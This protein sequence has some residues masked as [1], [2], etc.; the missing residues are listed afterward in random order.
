MADPKDCPLQFSEFKEVDHRKTCPR[1]SSVLER[2]EDEGIVPEEIDT[3]QLELE[4]LLAA[5]S[6]RMQQLHTESQVL[7]DWQDKKDGKKNPKPKE[8]ASPSGKRGRVDER[9]EK[10]SKKAKESGKPGATAPSGPGRPKAKNMQQKLQEYEFIDDA[11]EIP[12]IPRNDVPDRFWAS[13]E[14]YCGD[15]TSENMK[16]LDELIQAHENDAEYFKVPPLGR[17]YSTRW[18]QEDLLEEQKE[19][20]RIGEKK[21]GLSGNSAASQGK[22]VKSMLKRA[23]ALRE[24]ESEVCPFGPLTQRLISALVDENIMMPIEDIIMESNKVETPVE[25]KESPKINSRPFSVPHTRALEARIREE[26]F[27]QGLL[28]FDEKASD[29]EEDEVLA[30]LQ[31]R[32]AELRALCDRNQTQKQRLYKLAKDQIKRQ[33]LRQKMRGADN[34]VLECFRRLMAA[35]QKKRSPTKKERDQAA[36][37]LRDRDAAVR[38]LEALGPELYSC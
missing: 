4:T 22:E 33:E 24:R 12:R 20:G 15:I 34:E 32:Q 23:E 13:V 6:L 28:D 38:Q 19:G 18:A 21:K 35:R 10:P 11:P 5:V 29:G 1:Y 17:H 26:L 3:L 25:A 9:L 30:E 16:T 2:S 8:E 31:K 36:R 37:A 7:Q 14:P 27:N